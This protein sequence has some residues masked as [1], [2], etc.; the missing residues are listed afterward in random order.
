MTARFVRPAFAAALS[1]T[2][3]AP[4][5]SA[6]A[7]FSAEFV[8][9][10]SGRTD[11]VD[12]VTFL[13]ID[14]GVDVYG[15]QILNKTG[16]DV[17][18]LSLAFTGDFLNGTVTTQATSGLPTFGPFTV[19]DTFFVGNG[20]QAPTFVP[21][22][23]VDDGTALAGEG[24]VLGGVW[25]PDRATRTVAVF[26]VPS[27]ANPLT[28]LDNLNSGF[29]VVDGQFVDLFNLAP[30]PPPTPGDANGDCF[31]DLLDF[32][33]LAANYGAGPEA[34]GG[35]T[36]ADFNFD[37][38]VDLLDFDL[39][40]RNFEVDEPAHAVPLP[41]A[42]PEPATAALFAL[43]GVGALARRRRA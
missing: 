3:L 42:V 14:G 7:F 34:P 4:S 17:A 25:I 13:P 26:T 6:H 32:D 27:G 1:L 10:D 24:G 31:V 30:P 8:L 9:L 21:A 19:A 37:G 28:T 18:S 36:I 39:F 5:F 29:G 20:S 2:G 38:S 35:F 12:P 40:A 16:F 11:V 43:A 15:F 23:I 22:S 41:A 33:I